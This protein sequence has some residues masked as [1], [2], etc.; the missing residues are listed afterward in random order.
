MGAILPAECERTRMR[1]SLKLDGELSQV[2]HAMLR[3][4][5]RRCGACAE[6]AQD[7]GAVTRRIRKTPNERP[8]RIG[9]PAR[10]RSAGT[11][12][13]QA[14]AAVI[15]VVAA[16]AFGSLTGSLSSGRQEQSVKSA[17]TVRQS[18]PADALSRFVAQLPAGPKTRRPV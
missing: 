11:R 15:A 3:A 7:L 9:V 5:T 16:V 18:P 12:S 1:V 2:E 4:H 13:L 6:F 14:C 8:L 10:R 17:H